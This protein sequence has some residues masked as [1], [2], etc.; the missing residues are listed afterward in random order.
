MWKSEYLQF[1]VAA[2]TRLPALEKMF[3][4]LKQEKAILQELI[5]DVPSEENFQPE[6]EPNWIDYLDE[7]AIAWFADTFDYQ[8]DEGMVYQRL[9]ELTEPDLRFDHPMFNFPGN[10]DFESMIDSLFHNECIYDELVRLSPAEGKLI[11]TPLAFPFGGS[12]SLVALIESFGQI[13]TFDSWHEG[14]HKR[15]VIGW[16]FDRAIQ[17]VAAGQGVTWENSPMD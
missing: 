5:D 8:S 10:W 14:P 17:L 9:W 4:A 3:L 11:Y 13:V 6:S 7:E 15:R 1:D 16:N 2:P 12:E